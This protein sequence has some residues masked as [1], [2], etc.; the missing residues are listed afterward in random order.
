VIPDAWRRAA[1]EPPPA[2]GGGPVAAGA[3]RTSPEDFI[4]DE[5]LGFEAGGEGPH[6]LLQVRKRG[7]NTEWVSRE[8]ARLAGC[9]PFEVGFA[10]LKDRNAVTTQFF[11]VP[12]GKRAAGEFL[13]A[14]GEGYEVIGAAAHQRKLPRGALAGNRF[15]ITVRQ[16]ACDA[17]ALR[18]RIETIA[19]QG[20]PNY[21]GGQRFGR[22][23]GNLADVLRSAARIVSGNAGRARGRGDAGFMLSA[24][25]SVVF[26]A[27]LAERVVRNTW[28]TLLPGDV[29]N[30]DG[31]G[32]VFAVPDVDADLASRCAALDLHPTAPLPG[33][34]ASLATGE[35][36]ALE[37]TVAARFPEALAVIGHERMNAERR[38]MRIRVR[39][40]EHEYAEGVLRLRFELGAGS[41]ATTVLREIIGSADGE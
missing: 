30:L 25:R 15:T 23:A 28:N 24:A 18:A 31:R 33:A 26:N 32:S 34:G 27:I 7:A 38:A 3:L 16:V 8:L 10:G 37:E 20:V 17:A 40:V 36:L 41:F 11:T 5:I 14:S 4:V 35:V 21:F 22:E 12:R 13:G 19:R 29:A 9:K 1:L 2:W 39:S 6:A